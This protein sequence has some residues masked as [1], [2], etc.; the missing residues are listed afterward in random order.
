MTA[1]P[2]RINPDYEGEKC[3]RCKRRFAYPVHQHH[4]YAECTF[5][6]DYEVHVHNP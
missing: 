2:T 6:R 1:E 4:T 5:W 3:P